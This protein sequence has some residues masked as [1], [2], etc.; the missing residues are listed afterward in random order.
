MAPEAPS[1]PPAEGEQAE[2]EPGELDEAGRRVE[3]E[4]AIYERQAAS[5]PPIETTRHSRA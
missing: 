3:E 2:P 1:P 4:T 5:E